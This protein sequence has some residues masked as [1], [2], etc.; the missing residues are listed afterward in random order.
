MTNNIEDYTRT[1]PGSDSGLAHA[2]ASKL[3]ACAY[4]GTDDDLLPTDQDGAAP[5]APGEEPAPS[6]EGNP[7]AEALER[8]QQLFWLDRNATARTAL[9][10]QIRRMLPAGTDLS[11]VEQ[12]FQRYEGILMRLH[13]DG[14]EGQVG[15][16]K[17]AVQQYQTWLSRLRDSDNLPQEERFRTVEEMFRRL[18]PQDRHGNFPPRVRPRPSS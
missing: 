3:A 14:P 16:R 1:E 11:E 15:V 9:I 12:A 18:M 8:N 13:G 10:N 7:V 5:A 4:D 17:L 6:H 2:A